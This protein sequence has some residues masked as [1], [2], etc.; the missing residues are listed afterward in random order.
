[1][2]LPQGPRRVGLA[3]YAV[4]AL[5]VALLGLSVRQTVVTVLSGGREFGAAGAGGE[6]G[7]T[8][9]RNM[10][11][12]DS[13]V[14]QARMGRRDPFQPP[15]M[16]RAAVR[17][18][19]VQAAPAPP[20]EPRLGSLVYDNVAPTVQ[21]TVGEERSGWLRP[22]DVFHGW[23]VLEITRASVRVANGTRTRVLAVN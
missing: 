11:A 16:E 8:G 17:V 1:M 22:G 14:E 9:W 20:P 3:G 2:R 13:L 5:G 15:P 23:T 12:R 18:P 21:L 19:V 6:G 4:L 7:P 10:G